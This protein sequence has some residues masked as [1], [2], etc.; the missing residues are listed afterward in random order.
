MS[1]KVKKKV[2]GLVKV[3]VCG[4]EFDVP[5]KLAAGLKHLMTEYETNIKLA[6]E[7]ETSRIGI[8]AAAQGLLKFEAPENCSEG[9]K[10]ALDILQSRVD[11]SVAKDKEDAAK[12]TNA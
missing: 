12:E 11:E 4:G 9:F 8:L 3:Q 6:N 7:I 2:K 10:A 5:R 1:K